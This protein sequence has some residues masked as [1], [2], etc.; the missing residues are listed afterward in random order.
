M[1]VTE[2]AS[3]YKQE[4]NVQT[5]GKSVRA[6]LKHIESLDPFK[7]DLTARKDPYEEHERRKQM[8]INSRMV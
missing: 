1:N 4:E 8:A 2:M 7:G 6:K 3:I 5:R